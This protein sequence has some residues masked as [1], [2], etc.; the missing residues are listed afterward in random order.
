MKLHIYL[1]VF[2]FFV[3]LI[4]ALRPTSNKKPQPKKP[5]PVKAKPKG[6]PKAIPNKKPQPK[7]TPNKKPQP[8]KKPQSKPTPLPKRKPPKKPLVH[9]FNSTKISSRFTRASLLKYLATRPVLWKVK[10]LIAFF[11]LDNCLSPNTFRTPRDSGT[12]I[13]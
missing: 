13:C 2:I 4:E 1:L 7:A 3:S 6:K 10:F 11:A 5:L 8:T 12:R 9:P